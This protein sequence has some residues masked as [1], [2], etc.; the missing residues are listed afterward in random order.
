[1]NVS[2]GDRLKAVREAT[3]LTQVAFATKLDELAAQVFKARPRRYLPPT[4]SKLETEVQKA[5]FDD[6][7]IYAAIDPLHRGKLWLVWGEAVDATLRP[8]AAP[9]LRDYFGEEVVA[10]NATLRAAEKKEA[11]RKR[12]GRKGGRQT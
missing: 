7:A 11:A 4:I 12:S 3:G 10:A 8:P 2:V 9:P 6:I 1:M 5:D